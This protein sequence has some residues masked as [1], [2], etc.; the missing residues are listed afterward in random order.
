MMAVVNGLPKSFS[1]FVCK[2][3]FVTLDTPFEIRGRIAYWLNFILGMDFIGIRSIVGS[4]I[5]FFRACRLFCFPVLLGFAQLLDNC[6]DFFFWGLRQGSDLGI[7]SLDMPGQYFLHCTGDGSF[8]SIYTVG[9]FFCSPDKF[10]SDTI[11]LCDFFAGAEVGV[12]VVILTTWSKSTAL[13]IA[14]LRIF[15]PVR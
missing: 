10:G 9:V 5:G 11:R 12:H 13:L 14:I 4:N 1:I 8:S 6:R 15:T 2:T 3:A 7:G